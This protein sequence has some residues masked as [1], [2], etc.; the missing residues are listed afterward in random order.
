MILVNLFVV[1][2]RGV[3][4]RRSTGPMTGAL[5]RNPHSGAPNNSKLRLGQHTYNS[6]EDN[7][8]TYESY[9]TVCI[10]VIEGA[11]NSHLRIKIDLW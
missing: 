3:L 10:L 5:F 7:D 4:D 6:S 9:K 11:L 8:N 1:I 2:G